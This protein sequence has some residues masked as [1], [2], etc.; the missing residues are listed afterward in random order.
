M[1][2]KTWKA[3]IGNREFQFKMKKD[4]ASRVGRYIKDAL[5]LH[6][7]TRAISSS[8]KEDGT[9]CVSDSMMLFG[10]GQAP[11]ANPEAYQADLAAAL[12]K[13]A[14]VLIGEANRAECAAD[15]RAIY[16]KHIPILDKRTTP[17]QRAQ[18]NKE[19]AERDAARAAQ[20]K[21]ARAAHLAQFSNGPDT[22][23]IPI[24]Q[25]GNMAIYLETIYDDSDAQSD[26]YNPH[27]QM[28]PDLLLA[29]VPK[30]SKTQA[31]AR[32]AVSRYPELAGIEFTWHTENYSMGK[33]NY[34]ES[35]YCIDVLDGAE[36]RPCQYAV[37]FDDYGKSKYP[38]KAY[39]GIVPTHSHD[40]PPTYTNG[41][42]T[43]SHNLE[44]SGIE[45]RFAARPDDSI[46]ARLKAHGWR[47]SRFSKCWYA[48]QSDAANAFANELVGSMAPQAEEEPDEEEETVSADD[49][50]A[51]TGEE[52]DEE[53]MENFRAAC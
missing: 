44:K 33:G 6:Q 7:F 11:I 45:I 20:E 1:A 50:Q 37:K 26:Y 10:P 15:F 52:W 16:E 29:I 40:A 36:T 43:I 8:Y 19:R 21:A 51:I 14:S 42:A 18:E 48:K 39:P 28:G 3:Q 47:W 25:P 35:G 49:M 4:D 53:A 30:Q 23:M 34:L 5:Q 46:L 2:L 24:Q 31:L 32:L 13:W 12:D 17:E 27:R 38:Y 22:E 41:A 9:D